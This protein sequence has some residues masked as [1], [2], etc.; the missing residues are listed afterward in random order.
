MNCR[1]EAGNLAD[2]VPYALVYSIEVAPEV[3]L[4]IDDEVRSRIQPRIEIAPSL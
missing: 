4:P 2:L 3:S 1:A